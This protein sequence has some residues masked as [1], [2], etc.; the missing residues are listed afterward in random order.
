MKPE[1]KAYL[2]ATGI[3]LFMYF[4]LDNSTIFLVQKTYLNKVTVN[5]YQL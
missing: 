2:Q 4:F 5:I 3:L 1:P